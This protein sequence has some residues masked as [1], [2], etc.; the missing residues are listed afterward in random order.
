MSAHLQQFNLKHCPLTKGSPASWETSGLEELKSRFRW[1]LDSPGIGLITGAP[2]VG[3]T[4][5]LH[6]LCQSLNTQEYQVIYH[7]ETDF[8]RLDI[9]QQLA[10]DFGLATKHR[11]ANIWRAIKAHIL[12]MAQHKHRLPIWII[13]EAQNLPDEF[14]RDFPAF[15]NFAFDSQPLMTVWFLGHSR[16]L[17]KIKQ[18]VHDSLRSRIQIFVHFDPIDDASEFKQML[19]AAFKEA[20][21]HSS[22][23]SDSGIELIRFAS[24][25]KFRQAGIIIDTALQLGF[26]Q[27]LNHLPDDTIKQAIKELQK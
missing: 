7:S 21:A 6:H 4:A 19:T 22:L 8:G 25:G 12:E 10:L 13:D 5:A 15:L 1:L 3:K 24:Q 27:N 2:G 16:L 14:F 20:G 11:R 9:Y 17:Q 18:P 26:K 23:V